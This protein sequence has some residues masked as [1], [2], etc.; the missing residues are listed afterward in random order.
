MLGWGLTPD[1]RCYESLI[2]I[3]SHHGDGGAAVAVLDRIEAAGLAPSNETYRRLLHGLGAAGDLARAAQVYARLRAVGIP[4]DSAILGRLFRAVRNHAQ[5]VRT[6]A[7]RKMAALPGTN[8]P[9]R[10]AAAA[11]RSARLAEAYVSLLSWQGDMVAA[12]VRHDA[13][14]LRHL[15]GALERVNAVSD[16]IRLA[17]LHEQMR[18]GDLGAHRHA[19]KAAGRLR[20]PAAAGHTQQLAA[21]L[22]EGGSLSR[23]EYL[24]LLFSQFWLHG[25]KGQARGAGFVCA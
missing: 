16:C 19:L 4:P 12:G 6:E 20:T 15:L 9:A 18:P 10:R 1:L 24:V 11:E 5:L 17:Q 23:E 13:V 8:A 3:H 25:D 22:S 14:T 2:D 21:R 7:S